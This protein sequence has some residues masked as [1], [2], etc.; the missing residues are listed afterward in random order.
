MSAAQGRGIVKTVHPNLTT[1]DSSFEISRDDG[2]LEED[3]FGAGLWRCRTVLRGTLMAEAIGSTRKEVLDVSQLMVLHE[4]VRRDD[5]RE[6]GAHA[7]DLCE[8]ISSLPGD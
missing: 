1:A 2:D 8:Q 5:V 6:S 4:L 7:C 3:S